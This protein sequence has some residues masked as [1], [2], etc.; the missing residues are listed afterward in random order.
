MDDMPQPIP[1]I[2]CDSF[3][4]DFIDEYL[5][6]AS[7][8]EMRKYEMNLACWHVTSPWDR[9]AQRMF[10]TILWAIKKCFSDIYATEL[11]SDDFT[12]SNSSD[13][14][15]YSRHVVIKSFCVKNNTEARFFTNKLIVLLP[16]NIV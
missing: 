1:P 14:T 7:A 6:T 16:E 13:Q 8:E 3:G 2:A 10:E 4:L 15:K 5:D 12:L 9:K 11:C